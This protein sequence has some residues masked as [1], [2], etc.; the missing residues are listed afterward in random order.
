MINGLTAFQ[1]LRGLLVL[2]DIPN[3]HAGI[4]GVSKA[5]EREL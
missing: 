4:L 5:G 2:V 1:E 3:L